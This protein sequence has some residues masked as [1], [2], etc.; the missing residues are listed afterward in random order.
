MILTGWMHPTKTND[1]NEIVKN[2]EVEWMAEEEKL[3]SSN[4]KA[5]NAIFS[6]IDVYQFKLM[7]TYEV[8]KEALEILE[9]AHEGTKDVR[10][11]K[12]QFLTSLFENLRMKEENQ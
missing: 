4:S 3:A 11:L 12:L 10:L 8:A 9:T 5:L 6:A 1:N 7:S 2:P